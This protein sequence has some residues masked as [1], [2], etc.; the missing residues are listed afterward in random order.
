MMER[1][2]VLGQIQD[3]AE[4][5]GS[6]VAFFE[7]KP[8]LCPRFINVGDYLATVSNDASARELVESTEIRTRAEHKKAVNDSGRQ[9][10]QNCP[11]NQE[12]LQVLSA[13]A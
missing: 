3:T 9:H 2:I 6:A 13:A 8:W 5:V 4:S 12:D 1:S 11:A 10:D 7:Q